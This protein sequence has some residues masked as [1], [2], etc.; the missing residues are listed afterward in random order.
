[1]SYVKSIHQGRKKNWQ[2]HKKW[3][4]EGPYSLPPNA[5]ASITESTQTIVQRSMHLIH[6]KYGLVVGYVQSG[7]TANYT[8]LIS[9]AVDMGYTFIVGPA[10]Q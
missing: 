8:A 10:S 6:K 7:K 4:S 9:R 5:V 3:I 2:I 1:M